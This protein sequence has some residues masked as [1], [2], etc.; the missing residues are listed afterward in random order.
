MLILPL[1]RPLTRATF[2]LVTMLLVLAN[3]LVFF[4]LQA[5]DDETMEQ[6][7]RYYIDSGLGRLEAP[8]YRRYLLASGQADT[9]QAFDRLAADARPQFVA[10]HTL[11][12][13]AFATALHDGRLA[14]RLR[15]LR[16]RASASR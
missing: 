7:R 4:G 15:M 2:P 8:A 9:R 6:A 13:P 10:T 16:R 14:S 3:V 5:G 1:H 11:H 12:D